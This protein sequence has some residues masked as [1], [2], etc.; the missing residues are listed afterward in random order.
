MSRRMIRG[1]RRR[2]FCH[3]SGASFCPS[4]ERGGVRLSQAVV[5]TGHIVQDSGF[6]D[7]VYTSRM[8]DKAYS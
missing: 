6:T 8:M 1:F 2:S 3:E 4:Q 5:Y 7:V